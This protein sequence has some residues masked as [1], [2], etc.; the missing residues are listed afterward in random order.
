MPASWSGHDKQ[1]TR[2]G[3]GNPRGRGRNA[4]TTRCLRIYT[5]SRRGWEGGLGVAQRAILPVTLPASILQN[6][7]TRRIRGTLERVL[8]H[9][10][11]F[12][13]ACGLASAFLATRQAGVPSLKLKSPPRGWGSLVG[14]ATR[15]ASL[16]S[17]PLGVSDRVTGFD[18]TE[19]EKAPALV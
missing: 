5:H 1:N 3:W 2:P 13:S 6:S 15:S 18:T 16:P 11:D 19:K 12:G 8:C 7:G 9:G 17:T 10:R 14:A 4:C